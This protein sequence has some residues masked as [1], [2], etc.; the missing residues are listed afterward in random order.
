ML[1]ADT[2]ESHN[3]IRNIISIVNNNKNINKIAKEEIL[4]L[5]VFGLG[6]DNLDK[7]I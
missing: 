2:I 1:L 7:N 3:L 6:I 5:L 4:K